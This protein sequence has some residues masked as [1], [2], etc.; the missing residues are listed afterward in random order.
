MF[1]ST[2]RNIS[3]H[4]EVIFLSNKTGV[5]AE[6]FMV[7]FLVPITR[8]IALPTAKYPATGDSNAG[9]LA[10]I[11]LDN[12]DYHWPGFFT[13]KEDFIPSFLSRGAA[14]ITFSCYPQKLA[15]SVYLEAFLGD[16]RLRITCS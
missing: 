8:A 9:E 10:D 15:V 14:L 13:R 6:R 12:S 5:D 11:A 2:D 7:Q 3:L 1:R 16:Q 4:S